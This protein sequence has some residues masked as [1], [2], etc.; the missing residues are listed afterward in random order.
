MQTLLSVDLQLG[1]GRLVHWLSI[2]KLY[3]PI[4]LVRAGWFLL[5]YGRALFFWPFSITLLSMKTYFSV[6]LQLGQ[7]IF[8]HGLSFKTRFRSIGWQHL[9]LRTSNCCMCGYLLCYDRALFLFFD[10]FPSRFS[11]CKHYCQLISS[12]GKVGLCTGYRLKNC[13]SRFSLFGQ[14]D[15]CSV[16]V[17]H[18]FFDHFQSRFCPWKHTF[19]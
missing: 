3:V 4:F 2:K 15:F 13:M 6:A 14:A 19:L 16:T 12:S 10:H 5:C 8:R 18:F 9:E 1:Q 7:G 17:G 11:R